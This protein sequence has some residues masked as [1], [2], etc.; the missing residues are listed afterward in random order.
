MGADLA[1]GPHCAGLS[2]CPSRH[3]CRTTWLKSKRCCSP[4][5][6]APF[7]CRIGVSAAAPH[8]C[9]LAEVRATDQL[10]HLHSAMASHCHNPEP[11]DRRLP[12][13]AFRKP[14]LPARLSKLRSCVSAVFCPS[15]MIGRFHGCLSRASPIHRVFAV[16]NEDIGD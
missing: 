2:P 5:A 12:A 8:G 6:F 1:T 9:F 16:D 15:T 7:R 10:S 13:C 4:F 11:I 14:S 3:C